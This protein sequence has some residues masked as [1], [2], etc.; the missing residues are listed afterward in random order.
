MASNP[1]PPTE[2]EPELLY[3]PKCAA[4]VARSADLR[5]LLRRH[6]PPMWNS[7]RIGRRIGDGIMAMGI[8]VASPPST[9]SEAQPT[10]VRGLTLLDSVL[11]LAS[12]I[13]GSSIF[14]TAKDIAGPL[15]QPILFL[16]SGCWAAMISL[17][18]LRRLRRTRL[19]VPRLRRPIHLSARSLRRPAR[20][21]LRMDAVQRSQR[22]LDRRAG[23]GFG[24][25][26]GAVVPVISQEHVVSRRWA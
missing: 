18:A 1:Q 9:Q 7:T 17:F 2:P 4:E 19:D 5:R 20:I 15:P 14:L 24:R 22:R 8:P 13:I 21:P 26:H 11:L 16:G 25:V 12:G 10:L 23:R 3:C 6:M